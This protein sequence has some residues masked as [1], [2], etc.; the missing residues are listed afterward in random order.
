MA[1]SESAPSAADPETGAHSRMCATQLRVTLRPHLGPEKVG[2][3]GL[4]S[5]PGE[6]S[7][8]TAACPIALLHP[9]LDRSWKGRLDSR[10]EPA[11]NRVPKPKPPGPD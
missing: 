11:R 6:A 5:A 4:R 1:R 9:H 8:I 7:A 10:E 3:G 2:R